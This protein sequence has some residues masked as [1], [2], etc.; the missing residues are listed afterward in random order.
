MSGDWFFEKLGNDGSYRR[1]E[2]IV[3]RL[4]RQY[5]EDQ[6][7]PFKEQVRIADRVLDGIAPEGLDDLPGATLVEIKMGSRAFRQA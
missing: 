5:L 1:F 3:L 6:H 4:L 2:A 7:K